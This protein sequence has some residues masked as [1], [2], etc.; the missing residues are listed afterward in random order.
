VKQ[1]KLWSYSEPH[2]RLSERKKDERDLIRL[3]ETYP[4]LKAVYPVELR[5]QMDGR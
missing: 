2:R 4:E 5:E 3:A 1:G